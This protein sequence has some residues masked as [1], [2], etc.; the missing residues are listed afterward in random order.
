MAGTEKLMP[1]YWG[2]K[3][4]AR[5]PR[6]LRIALAYLG[7]AFA[8]YTTASGAVSFVT[9]LR[10]AV[11]AANWLVNQS[12]DARPMLK[13][14]ASAIHS[15]VA[16]WR[17]VTDPIVE[18]LRLLTGVSLPQYAI[19]FIAIALVLLSGWPRF[20][21]AWRAGKPVHK[22]ALKEKVLGDPDYPLGSLAEY[23][24]ELRAEG[25]S[26]ASVIRILWSAGAL[27]II[28]TIALLLDYAYVTW[29]RG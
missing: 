8:W 2:A 1:N 28:F 21:V 4:V 9:D 17:S 18:H 7:V 27:A 6:P 16:I 11:D 19:D 26:K 24:M 13:A 12:G 22:R 5:L 3:L 14:V 20:E 29:W 23:Y 15:L 10:W 25:E